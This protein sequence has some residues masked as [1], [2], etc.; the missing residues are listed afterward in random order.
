MKD[1]VTFTITEM[2]KKLNV[3]IPDFIND[4]SNQIDSIGVSD[5]GDIKNIIEFS[6]FQD[7]VSEYADS[8]TPIYY[9]DIDAQYETCG[10]TIDDVVSE[11]LVEPMESEGDISK[12][13]Q[14]ALY[15]QI[16]QDTYKEIQ[17]FVDEMETA[18]S[19]SNDLKTFEC[20][21]C[22]YEFFKMFDLDKNDHC[23]FCEV[24]E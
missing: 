18:I 3:D 11:G 22:G 14:V 19:E 9:S 20:V 21:V 15:M 13:K 4:Y 12:A 10:F 5:T 24:Q 2:A 8:N 17:D 23:E 6:Y 1:Q 7:S 16:E